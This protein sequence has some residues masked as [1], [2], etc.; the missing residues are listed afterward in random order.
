MEAMLCI[1]FPVPTQKKKK[2]GIP[3]G[4]CAAARAWDG[5]KNV[6][7]RACDARVFFSP[8]P[9]IHLFSPCL[10]CHSDDKLK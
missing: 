6:L 7:S 8:P 5:I 1:L 9:L 2:K 4:V 10:I 3:F